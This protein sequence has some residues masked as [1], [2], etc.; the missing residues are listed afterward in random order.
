MSTKVG[1]I[2]AGNVGS[3]LARGLNRAGHDVRTATKDY[4]ALREM[5]TWADAVILAVP[6]GAIDDIVN[7]AREEFTG[8]TIVDVTNAIGDKMY[9]ALN[10]DTSGAEKLQSKLPKAHIVKAF[11]TVFAQHMDTGHVLGE[12]IS[13]FVAGDD[14]D[15]KNTVLKLASDIGFDAVDAGPLQNAQLLEQLGILDIQFGHVVGMGTDIG[16]KLIHARQHG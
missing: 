5:V 1:I 8:K 13:A 9:Y 15:A 7:A 16:F 11:N 14:A 6:F 4:A 10:C 3:A 12:Q 2:G